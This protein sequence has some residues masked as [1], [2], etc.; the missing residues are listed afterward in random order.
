MGGVPRATG[1]GGWEWT[2]ASADVD[3]SFLEGRGQHASSRSQ[4]EVVE[5]STKFWKLNGSGWEWVEEG[6]SGW[7]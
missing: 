1:V 5:V 4:V 3:G 7:K 2:E 6:G